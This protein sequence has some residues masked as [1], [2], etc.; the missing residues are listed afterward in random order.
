VDIGGAVGKKIGPFPA[1]VWVAV[2]GG[3]LAIAYFTTRGSG[4][5]ATLPAGD[6]STESGVGGS[7]PGFLPVDAP[8]ASAPTGPTKY[9]D[10]ETWAAAA[11]AWLIGYGQGIGAVEAGTA[12]RKYLGSEPLSSRELTLINLVSRNPPDGIGPAPNVP[13]GG[14]VVPG[15]APTPIPA[16]TPTPAP[17]PAPVP[18]PVQHIPGW[19]GRVFQ[20]QR[21]PAKGSTLSGI[22]QLVYGN[23]AKW[24][25]IYN[26]NRDRIRTPNLVFTGTWL[27]IP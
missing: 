26:A 17:K 23:A 8:V 3:A 5:A 20:V 19:K 13:I 1:G 11:V 7:T 22:A 27:R 25:T 16:P 6:V 10:N 18:V 12:V 9:T 14:G 4:K 21:W 2:I 24:P 15:P